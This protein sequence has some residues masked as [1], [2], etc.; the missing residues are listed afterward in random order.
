[1]ATE[2]VNY[3]CPSCNGTMR[4]DAASAKLICNSCGSS[5][6]PEDIGKAY[7]AKQQAADAKAQ[8]ATAAAEAA[9]AQPASSQEAVQGAPADASQST[10]DHPATPGASASAPAE[11]L[12]QQ[13]ID[14]AVDAGEKAEAAAGGDPVAAYLERA[15][16]NDKE[17]E[18]LRV[19]TCSS[20]GASLTCDATTAVEECPYCG[21]T[22]V[23]PGAF[24][25]NAKPDYIL[26]FKMDKNAATSAL[27]NYYK[28]KR[29]LPKEFIANNKVQHIQGIYVPFWLYDGKAEGSGN[30]TATQVQTAVMGREQIIT[31]NTYSINRAGE[32][33]FTKVPADGSAKMPDDHMDAIE[34]F[35]YSELKPFSV[36][37]LPGFAAERY[38][39]DAKEC[40]K[41]VEKRMENTLEEQLKATVSGYSQIT[42]GGVNAN[43]QVEKVSQALL[44][45]WLLHSQFQGKDY[46]FAMNGQ[47]G[48]LIGDLPV[49]PA[50]VAGCFAISFVVSVFLVALIASFMSSG[51]DP[52][53]TLLEYVVI[54]AALA[55]CVCAYFYNEHKTTGEQTE[56]LSYV[57]Q[58]SFNLTSQGDNLINSSVSRMPLGGSGGGIGGGG[59]GGP[60][61]F[62]GG[63]FGGGTMFGNF[64]G[65]SGGPSGGGFGGP[66][67]GGP[68]GFGGFG[69]PG[70]GGPGGFGGPGRR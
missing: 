44:P 68:G 61:G 3:Q 25:D 23:V 69:G 63:G 58:G 19:F 51:S 31:T 32:I 7:A 40:Q 64:D 4:Y 42:V 46:L 17:R 8:A 15:S 13:T 33:G 12:T 36:A 70:M 41:R 30:W 47:S 9:Q 6:S 43:V 18:G 55:A 29:F 39:Q 37:Y 20:C 57:S 54:P 53:I 28:G 11:T 34:P 5:W 26:P 45:V 10:P 1:M 24:V 14:Q 48:R 59:M 50:K 49:S 65:R 35:D 62:G 21:N 27:Q 2:S 67:P 22:A 56:A 52:L 66:G 60:G 16:W 38:D